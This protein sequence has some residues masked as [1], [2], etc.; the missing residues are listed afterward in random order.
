M[1]TE[2]LNEESSCGCK[3]TCSVPQSKNKNL[4]KKG[5]LGFMA[6]MAICCMAPL[7]IA[8]FAG[9]AVLMPL[10]V[11]FDS[12]LTIALVALSIGGAVWLFIKHR[13]KHV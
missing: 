4:K 6:A 10:P 3:S 9:S 13:R 12:P 5:M 8:F 11:W 7:G 1:T 2:N